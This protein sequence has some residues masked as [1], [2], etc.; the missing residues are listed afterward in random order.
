M[1]SKWA[2]ALTKKNQIQNDMERYLIEVRT[3]GNYHAV[4][5]SG[6][7]PCLLADEIKKV[8]NEFFRNEEE[9][10]KAKAD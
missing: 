10:R 8:V 3:E 4:E 9:S 1:S 6:N 5:F 2:M 7:T